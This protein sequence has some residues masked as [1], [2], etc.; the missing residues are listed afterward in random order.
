MAKQEIFDNPF[1]GT[2]ARLYESFPVRRNE[3]DLS[4]LRTALALLA[5]GRVVG[6]FPEGTRSR[7]GRMQ[8]AHPGAAMIALRSGVPI[9]PVG[10]SGTET[11]HLPRLFWR[12]FPRPQIRIVF[13]S[14]FALPPRDRI[15]SESVREGTAIIVEKIAALLPERYRPEP[16][17]AET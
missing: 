8:A 11:V 2:L 10:I 13:G 3:A 1:S 6:I 9:L 14:P 4:A 17:T 16:A 5:A 12:P 7:S 15:T